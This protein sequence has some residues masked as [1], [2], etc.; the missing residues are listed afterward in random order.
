WTPRQLED[1]LGESDGAWAAELLTVTAGGTFEHGTSTLQLRADPDDPERWASVRQR[2]LDAR[3]NRARPG[4][5]DKVVAAWNGLAIAALA[6]AGVALERPD[7]VDAATRAGELLATVHLTGEADGAGAADGAASPTLWRTSRNG[8]RGPGAGV[9]DDYGCVAAGF[10][11]LLGATGDPAW[12]D[13]AGA[14]LDRALDAFGAPDGGF[15]DTA[16]DAE[17]LVLRPRDP[18]D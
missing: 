9:L 3:A 13:R 1:V 17:Q 14:L 12:F 18:S 2:L 4:R 10:L 8:I 16:A 5:D 15:Y 11:S 6:E 7:L